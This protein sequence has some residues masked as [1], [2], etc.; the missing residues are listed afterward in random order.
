MKCPQPKR[1]I[2]C[3][4]CGEEG[5]RIH[6]CPY[7]IDL[8]NIPQEDER[9]SDEGYQAYKRQRQLNSNLEEDIEFR[10]LF[11]NKMQEVK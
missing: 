6:D 4:N 7:P 1:V 2:K 10:F 8:D 3:S 5:H 9:D 11:P